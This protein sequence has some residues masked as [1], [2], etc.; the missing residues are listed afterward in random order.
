MPASSPLHTWDLSL[1]EARSLQERLAGEL[2]F[3][4]QKAGFRWA[5]GADV[6]FHSS[7]NRIVAAVVLVDGKSGAV[8]EECHV[9]REATFPYIPGYLSFREAPAVLEA[10]SLLGRLPEVL[11]LDGQGLA[12]PRRFGLACHLGLWLGIPT[13]GCAKSRLVGDFISPGPDPGSW[14]DL[15]DKGEKVGAV[16]RTRKKV[17]PLFISPGHLL[18]LPLCI[19]TVLDFC[20]GFR[21]PEPTRQAH[22]LVTR[23]RRTLGPR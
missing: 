4:L 17:K 10:C 11:L 20:R 6:A 9:V 8:A 14:T 3:P 22:L 16:L 18:P 1:A 23:L 21:L 12:H 5:A 13:I 19:R 2:H 7:S 15:T